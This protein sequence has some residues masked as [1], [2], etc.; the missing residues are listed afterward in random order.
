MKYTVWVTP[1]ASKNHV[2]QLDK[3]TLKVWV[4]A[5]PEKGNANRAMLALLAEH[6]DVRKS[7]V[8]LLAGEAARTK[9]VEVL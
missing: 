7:A 3:Q 6:F 9:I 8:V 2:E 1:N 4:T 5:Q